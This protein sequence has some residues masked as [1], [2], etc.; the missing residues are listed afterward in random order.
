[1]AERERS[2]PDVLANKDGSRVASIEKWRTERR[3]E[4]LDLFRE[5]VYGREPLQRPDSLRFQAAVTERMMGGEALCKQ[6]DITFEGE[7]GGGRIALT[8][9]VPAKAAKP[10]PAFLL[11]NNREPGLAD[12]ERRT[13]SG[14]WP[15]EQ[16]VSRGYAAA[17]FQLSDVDPDHHDGFANG[18]HGIFDRKISPRPGN[19]WGTIA[20]WAWGACRVMDYFES[21]PDVDA[22]RV[23]VVGH[24]RGGKTALWAGAVDERFAMVISNN[25]G[26]TGAALARGKVGERIR[27]IN[28]RFP[29]WFADNYKQFNDRE[30]ELPVD[31][32]MLLALIAPRVLY[33]S[34]ASEDEW[35]DPASEFAA[36]L[37]AEPV[38]RLYGSSGLGTERRPPADTPVHGDRLGYHIRTGKHDLTEA[39]WRMFADLADQYMR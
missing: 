37:A 8:L 38:F 31:Q 39:D 1:M 32:H 27:D 4:L 19:A 29:H 14:F 3:P 23:A 22:G 16:L 13:V 17:V 24:S 2:I 33:V 12:P 36:L 15:A 28:E 7:G 20:A 5:Y 9:F 26:S 11:L 18:V 10:A 25:S 30:E 34:S 21:D 6:V 35:A